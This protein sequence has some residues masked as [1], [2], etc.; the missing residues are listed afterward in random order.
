MLLSIKQINQVSQIQSIVSE[1]TG[2]K[3]SAIC[4]PSRKSEIVIAR[5]LSMHFCRWNTQIPL[6]EIAKLHGKVNH[7]T[8]IHAD[9]EIS[10]AIR[11]NEK[12]KDTYDKIQSEINSLQNS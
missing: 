1:L 11:K 8:V 5:H 6:L 10:Y 9:K 7:A 12:L 2:I 3:L 4:S